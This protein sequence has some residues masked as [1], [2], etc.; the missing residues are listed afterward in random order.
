MKTT[1]QLPIP[2]ESV[3]EQLVCAPVMATVPVGAVPAPHTVTLTA[4]VWPGADGS[5]V[6]AVMVVVVIPLVT[7]WLAV[8]ELLS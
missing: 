5:G 3:I 7:V 4:T 2:P 1:L 8:S 6:S